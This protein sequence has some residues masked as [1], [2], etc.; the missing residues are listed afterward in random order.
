MID[1]VIVADMA[2]E[3]CEGITVW[4]TVEIFQE[5]NVK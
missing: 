1:M 2:P 3:A 5:G 4:E